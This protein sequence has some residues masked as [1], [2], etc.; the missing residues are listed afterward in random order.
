[1]RL[2][3]K[4]A[5]IAGAGGGIGTA[6]PVLFAQEG[7]KVVLAARRPGPLEAI[8]A[9]IAGLGG[10]A[11][12]VSADLVTEAGARKAAAFAQE[13]YGRVDILVNN[14]GDSAPG[15]GVPLHE[16]PEALWDALIDI[17]LKGLYLVARAALPGMIA[18]G[19]GVIIHLSSANPGRLAAHPGYG[20]GKAALIGL[21]QSLARQYRKDNIRAVAIALPGPVDNVPAG[22]VGPPNPRVDRP[23]STEDI[24]YAALYLASGEAAWVSGAVLTVDGGIEVSLLRPQ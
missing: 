14:L 19:G 17:N 4:V 23:G 16:T 22:S 3:G 12:W 1:M 24:A 15:R 2:Q 20:A 9:Q 11:A 8:A 13:K 6:V 7:A 10:E 5:L 21:T 18:Q